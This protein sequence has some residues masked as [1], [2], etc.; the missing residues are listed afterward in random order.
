VTLV[1]PLIISSRLELVL[2]RHAAVDPQP[3]SDEYWAEVA[4]VV[5]VIP[6]SLEVE[7]E[8]LAQMREI[9]IPRLASESARMYAQDA[10]LRLFIMALLD[11]PRAYLGVP[12]HLSQALKVVVDELGRYFRAN[13]RVAQNALDLLVAALSG[14][15]IA[16]AVAAGIKA[17]RLPFIPK[18]NGVGEGMLLV[19]A[20]ASR[21]FRLA[22]YRDRV[23]VDFKGLSAIDFSNRS[24]EVRNNPHLVA[25]LL[26]RLPPRL[27]A[28]RAFEKHVFGD[29]GHPESGRMALAFCCK[30]FVKVWALMG[31]PRDWTTQNRLITLA[32]W[33]VKP[34]DIDEVLVRKRM[35]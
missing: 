14:R 4:D 2:P 3:D 1:S 33:H 29:E 25:A 6:P 22:Y 17:M 7:S 31:W 12:D 11:A 10:S 27:A 21:A 20:L 30:N 18:Y 28:G 24:H 9:I 23:P 15:E 32:P 5:S 35:A 34:E 13:R 16:D 8:S 26:R 19:G